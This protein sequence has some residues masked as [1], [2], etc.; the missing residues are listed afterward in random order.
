MS[1]SNGDKKADQQD[2]QPSVELVEPPKVVE[3]QK[4]LLV[5]GKE[6]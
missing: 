1:C 2:N 3:T 6:I 5:N 4:P